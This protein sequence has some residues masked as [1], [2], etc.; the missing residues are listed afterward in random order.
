MAPTARSGPS[1]APGRD[2]PRRRP[3][4]AHPRPCPTAPRPPRAVGAPGTRAR[5]RGGGDGAGGSSRRGSRGLQHPHQRRPRDAEHVGRPLRRQSQALRHDRHGEPLLHRPRD[6]GQ[7]VGHVRAQLDLLAVDHQARRRSGRSGGGQ[8]IHDLSALPREFRLGQVG[9]AFN[10]L[11]HK[12]LLFSSVDDDRCAHCDR[13]TRFERTSSRSNPPLRTAGPPS[14]HHPHA[15]T[16]TKVTHRA[17]G[18]PSPPLPRTVTARPMIP[19]GPSADPTAGRRPPSRSSLASDYPPIG[20]HQPCDLSTRIK[21]TCLFLTIP[22]SNQGSIPS[23]SPRISPAPSA[24][25]E[26]RPNDMPPTHWDSYYRMRR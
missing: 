17:P 12:S 2:R 14:T 20:Y 23:L 8:R 7:G 13:S 25:Q 11:I 16:M 15:D 3:Q 26:L 4:P 19:I 22:F 6:T 18:P 5:R 21:R 24:P 10:P 9:P 1:R